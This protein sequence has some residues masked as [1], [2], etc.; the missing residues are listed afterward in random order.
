MGYIEKEGECIPKK[1]LV[2]HA[3]VCVVALGTQ[4]FLL[5]KREMDNFTWHFE[6][7]ELGVRNPK[8]NQEK[9][10]VP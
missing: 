1:S 4:T 8:K 9:E 3:N 5:A 10:S 7:R 2:K 6:E